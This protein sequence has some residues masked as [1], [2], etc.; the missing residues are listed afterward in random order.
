MSNNSHR[1]HVLVKVPQLYDFIAIALHLDT[2]PTSR[3][4]TAELN[5]G[6]YLQFRTPNCPTESNPPT[7]AP[8]CIYRR[9]PMKRA[10]KSRFRSVATNRGTDQWWVEVG[11]GPRRSTHVYHDEIGATPPP[12]NKMNVTPHPASPPNRESV[13]I[14]FYWSKRD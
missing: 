5:P 13:A 10:N 4:P 2:Y 8:D 9:P 11:P 12:Q 1:R 3:Q 6:G 7:N 14:D